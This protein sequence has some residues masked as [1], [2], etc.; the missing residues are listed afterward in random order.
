MKRNVVAWAALIVSTAALVSSR[1]VTRPLPAAPKITAEGQKA[2]QALSEAYEAVADFVK[3]SVVQI[4]VQ[5][6]AG[7]MVPRLRNP[8][9]PG[10]PGLPK[11][12][13]PKELEELFKRFFGPDAKPEGHPE[14]QQFR[15]PGG[16]VSEGTGSGFVFDERGHILTN[17]HV[18]ENA[19][20]IVVTFSDGTEVAAKVVGVDPQADVAVIK[21][22]T[23]TYR[24]L[25]VGQSGKLRV[26]EL[27]MAVGSP[28]GLSHSV[29]TGIISATDR[30]SVG[31]N[32]YES[33]LQTDAAINPGNS[34]GPLVNMAGQVVGINSA[35]VTQSRGNEGV[36]F[37]IPIDMA[38]TIAENLIKFG[39]VQRSRVG[40]A[41]QPLTP[42]L[43]KQVGLDPNIKGVVV[44]DIV[45][46][47]PAEKAGLKPGDVI[48]GFNGVP[49]TSVPTFRLTVSASESGK[50]FGLKY[51]REGKE[52]STTI[53]PAP[54]DKVVF[55]MEKSAAEAKEK[56]VEKPEN[57]EA[58]K[59][60]ISDFGLE[61]QELTSELTAQFGLKKDLKGLLVSGVKPGSPAEAAGIEAGMVVTKVVRD[62]QVLGVTTVKEFDAQA[63]KADE[64]A[65]YVEGAN[66]PGRFVTLSKVKKD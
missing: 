25:P 35:I 16:G 40:I 21:V 51:W 58:P 11:G 49:V 4:S 53:V 57:P 37:A 52:R 56:L 36:G 33:F 66:R 63:S 41:L 60:T 43:A 8:R 17:N 22:E 1:G 29:T 27:V 19:G 28:F 7:A 15:G 9:G 39:K 24:P 12:M 20:K 5:R 62:Q 34:G 38:T 46:G 42:I 48:T 23:T 65:V 64:L 50:E 2:A 61:V 44:G 13:D 18:V 47:S 32:D 30:N 10:G 31:I 3:P 14:Q 45:P 54:A 6:K 55:D 59:A 26:G